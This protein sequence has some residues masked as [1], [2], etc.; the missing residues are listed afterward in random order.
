V[1]RDAEIRPV[2]ACYAKVDALRDAMQAYVDAMHA[3]DT[4]AANSAVD[5]MNTQG[6]VANAASN[7]YGLTV[8]AS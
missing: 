7:A 2:G 4:Q 6:N 8:C 5:Q 3:H 1:E